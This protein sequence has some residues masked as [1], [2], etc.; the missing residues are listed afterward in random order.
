M[1][2]LVVNSLADEIQVGGAEKS[3]SI[4][5]NSWRSIG[6]YVDVVALTPDKTHIIETQ[7]G[8][9]I[10]IEL[11]NY[12][13]PF[14]GTPRSRSAR[15]RW[16]LRDRWNSD[17]AFLLSKALNGRPKY[18]IAF[19][20][21]LTGFSRSVLPTLSDKASVTCL[22]LRDY[23]LIH[24]NG[25]SDTLGFSPSDLLAR[26]LKLGSCRVFGQEV[27]A[28][29]GISEDIL[30]RHLKRGIFKQKASKVIYNPVVR[31]A[32]SVDLHRREDEEIVVGFLGRLIPEKGLH[33]LL[34]VLS[35][36]PGIAVKVG[37]GR[38]GEYFNILHAR[39][40]HATN[41]EFLGRVNPEDFFPEIDVLA[42]PSVWNEPFGRVVPEAYQFGKP[43]VVN[44]TGGLPELVKMGLTGFVLNF[45]EIERA[46]SFFLQL[47]RG[48]LIAM[49]D[50]CLKYSSIFDAERISEE[51]LAFFREQLELTTI[52]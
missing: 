13:W 29:I 20:N 15:L 23:S 26:V 46:R 22:A 48:D 3:I 4:L 8:S 24:P 7:Q 42:V 51:Y 21:L 18:D 45:T 27:D 14:D 50:E 12:Y 47:M 37:G 43:V 39:F 11:L 16:H 6:C 33:I 17:M 5:V 30:S 9:E 25:S 36:V 38:R 31:T 32:S 52:K 34:E 28:V 41:V 40:G 2:I 35:E 19:V 1:R 49:G 44:P 10:Y